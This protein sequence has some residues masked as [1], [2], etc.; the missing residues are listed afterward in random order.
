MKGWLAWV[1]ARHAALGAV[2]EIRII[3]RQRRSNAI[4]AG[5]FGP[6]D[7]DDLVDALTPLPGAPRSSIPRGDHPRSGEANIYFTLHAVKPELRE[8]RAPGISRSATTAKDRDIAAYTLFAVDVDPGRPAGV[9]A[10]EDEKAAALEVADAVAAWLSERGVGCIRADSGNGYHLLV[11]LV[12]AVGDDA[13]AGASKQAHELLKLLDARFSTERAK[14]DTAVANPSRIF[15][16][17]GTLAVKGEP[18]DE[19]PHRLAS[20]DLD[21]VPADVDLFAA[22]AEDLAARREASKPKPAPSPTQRRSAGAGGAG[23]SPAWK[24]WRDQAVAQLDLDAVYGDL[25]TG[26]ASG[27]GW[28]QCRD[29]DS[30]SGDKNPSAGVADGTGEAERGSYHS[31]RSG[32]T[33]SVFDFLVRAGRAADFKAACRVVGDL[34][35][36]PLPSSRR[37]KARSGAEVME[38]FRATW[39]AAE[40]D[41][42]RQ[43]AVRAVIGGLLPLPAM[44]R[45]PL[46]KEVRATSGLTYEVFRETVAE[47]KRARKDRASQ[48]SPPPPPPRGDRPVVEFIQN[49]DTID[50]LFGAILAVVKPADRLFT[51]GKDLVFVDPGNGPINVHEKNIGGLVASLVELRFM[52]D[53]EDGLAFVRYGVLPTDLARAFV[54]SPAVRRRLPRLVMYTR[55]PTFDRDWS[56]IGKP[57]FHASHGIYYDGPLVEP[58]ES[59]ELLCQ[60]LSDFKWKGEADRVNFVGALLTAVT[61]PHWG[62]GHPFLAINGNKPGV[63]KSTLARVL[64]VVVEG[65]EPSTVSF[66]PDDTEFEKQLA[67]RVEAGDRVIVIDNAK[68]RRSIQSPVLERCITDTRINFRRLGSN[69]AISRPV[70]DLLICLTMNLTHLGTDLRR[71]ALPVNLEMA[72]SVRDATYARADI[73]GFVIENRLEIVAELAGMVVAWV[74]AGRPDCERPARHSTGQA[75]AGTMDAILRL[76]GFDGFL[77]NF[78]E[79]EHAFDPQ[80]QLML[81]ICAEHRARPPSTAAQWADWLADPLAER[82]RDRNGNEKSTRGKATVVGRLFTGYLDAGFAVDGRRYELVRDYPEGSTRSATY[83][84]REVEE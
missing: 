28:L 26:K 1:L 39:E 12:A 51:T 7:L 55:S 65:A 22:V 31:F 20:V 56:F 29:P 84:F 58:R 47:V 16:V 21:D 45:D 33:I 70:N 18:S 72:T 63:G 49:R 80:Y 15:K 77:T 74:T 60:A 40:D 57:G 83:R 67:T 52:V 14:V 3:R 36:L 27:A 37:G 48:P 2:T 42:A 44:E 50:G 46:L 17:Y 43:E 30:P 34:T 69:T 24:A 19:R 25:L 79:S 78:D 76:S 13:V 62:R 10:T 6:E 11:P 59:L 61:M 38:A 23:P 64:G 4:Y 8:G 82:F 73:V 68:T 9:S 81:D 66:V 71:R 41:A 32:E 54:A 53:T 5:L 35:G 75:W